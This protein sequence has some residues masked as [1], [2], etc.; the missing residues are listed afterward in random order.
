ME[1]LINLHQRPYSWSE[2][3]VG[4]KENWFLGSNLPSFIFFYYYSHAVCETLGRSTMNAPQKAL[5]KDYCSLPSVLNEWFVPHAKATTPL[6]LLMM[7]RQELV[8]KRSCWGE[9]EEWSSS[10]MRT[11]IGGFLF[12]SFFCLLPHSNLRIHC[13]LEGTWSRRKA[14]SI[15]IWQDCAWASRRETDKR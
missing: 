13:S 14:A 7:F 11:A 3:E 6:L 2:V 5:R 12:P 15:S 4:T 10:R 1:R 8:W 9:K